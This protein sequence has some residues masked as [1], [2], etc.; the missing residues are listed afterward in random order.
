MTSHFFQ[1]NY[2]VAMSFGLT[3]KTQHFQLLFFLFPEGNIQLGRE[4]YILSIDEMWEN[5]YP[6]PGHVSYDANKSKDNGM[7]M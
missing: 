7:K 1:W 6:V 4:D 2:V 3:P 5:D